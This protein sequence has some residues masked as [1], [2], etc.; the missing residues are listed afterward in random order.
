MAYAL[1]PPDLQLRV[2]AQ[3]DGVLVSLLQGKCY[4]E[5]TELNFV[6][7]LIASSSNMVDVGANVGFW[8]VVLAQI[9]SSGT[10]RVVAFDAGDIPRFESQ[11]V[12]E[13]IWR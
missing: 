2:L 12:L 3:N 5:E 4:H 1:S 6:R 8:T 11:L 7:R 13:S 9:V 10:G